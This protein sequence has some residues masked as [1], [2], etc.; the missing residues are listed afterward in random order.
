VNKATLTVELTITR[1][2]EVDLDSEAYEQ[3]VSFREALEH[4]ALAYHDEPGYLLDESDT[5][6]R[7][8]GRVHGTT[9]DV[10]LEDNQ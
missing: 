8:H 5:K 6:V 3:F 2:Y 7:T 9:I 1:T 10:V 4:D